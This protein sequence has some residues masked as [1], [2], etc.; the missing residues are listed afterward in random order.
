MQYEEIRRQQIEQLQ[1]KRAEIMKNN[2]EKQ[3]QDEQRLQDKKRKMQEQ[4]Q[5][6]K[7]QDQKILQE[8]K[9]EKERQRAEFFAK[10]K[11]GSQQNANAAAPQQAATGSKVE[12]QGG[13]KF[14]LVGVPDCMVDPQPEPKKKAAHHEEVMVFDMSSKPAAATRPKRQQ[15]GANRASPRVEEDSKRELTGQEAH[16]RAQFDHYKQMMD[17]VLGS[18]SELKSKGRHRGGELVNLD[19]DVSGAASTDMGSSA[20]DASEEAAGTAPAQAFANIQQRI[21]DTDGDGESDSEEYA[22]DFH[23]MLEDV[24]RH[25]ADLEEDRDDDLQDYDSTVTQDANLDFQLEESKA[26]NNRFAPPNESQPDSVTKKRP[27]NAA[28]NQSLGA[29]AADSV[30]NEGEVPSGSGRDLDGEEKIWNDIIE[31]HGRKNYDTVYQII[32][33]NVSMILKA[34]ICLRFVK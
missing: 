16:A 13:V 18:D 4:K 30:D 34:R 5:K 19:D 9:Q 23:S 29:S 15:W 32:D 14:E 27:S 2:I 20:R 11:R 33:S 26:D 31:R 28:L 6:R 12:T 17:R 7:E 10:M 1:K 22:D 21:D 3:R 25:Q 24:V 8:Q